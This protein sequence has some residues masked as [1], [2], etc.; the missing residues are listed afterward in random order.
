MG[1]IEEQQNDEEWFK[2]SE[3]MESLNQKSRSA[4]K[5]GVNGNIF[6]KFKKKLYGERKE[7]AQ[8]LVGE[9]EEIISNEKKS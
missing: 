9:N 2:L 7:T 8:P 5:Y 3:T 4:W 6:W 1:N